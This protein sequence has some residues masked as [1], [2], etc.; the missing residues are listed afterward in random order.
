MKMTEQNIMQKT[1]DVFQVCRDVSNYMLFATRLQKQ[2]FDI[3]I[4]VN[5]LCLA[6]VPAM[7]T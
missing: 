3:I 4:D 7:G 1:G 2:C 5:S 6:F